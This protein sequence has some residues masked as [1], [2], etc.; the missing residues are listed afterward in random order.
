MEI[1]FIGKKFI[2]GRTESLNFIGF[3]LKKPHKLKHFRRITRGT[4]DNVI[5]ESERFF[6]RFEKPEDV[7][8]DNDFA[9]A[10]SPSYP[11]VISKVPLW[12]LKQ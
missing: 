2:K 10:G 9:L 12:Y 11:R 7:K 5:K 3:S 4:G 6:E 8:M 1:D